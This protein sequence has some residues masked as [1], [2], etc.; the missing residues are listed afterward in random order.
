MW[1]LC[2]TSLHISCTH[3][4]T[5]DIPEDD[6]ELSSKHVRAIVKK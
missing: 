3:R 4:K 2:H 6:K 5:C 1:N